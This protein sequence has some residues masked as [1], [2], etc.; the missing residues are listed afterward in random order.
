MDQVEAPEAAY[1]TRAERRCGRTR[2]RAQSRRF[3]LRRHAVCQDT[4]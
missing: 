2:L 4:V 1:M 3:T